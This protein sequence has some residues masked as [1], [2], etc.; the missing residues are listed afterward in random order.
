MFDWE[1]KD[2]HIHSV[3]TASREYQVHPKRLRK[4]LVALG[5]ILKESATLSDNQVTFDARQTDKLMKK[6]AT[7]ATATDVETYLG[8]GRV[9]TKILIENGLIIPFVGKDAPGSGLGELLFAREGLDA[10]LSQLF[11]DARPVISIPENA[12]SI[13][14][15]AKRANCGAAE[16]VRL[17]VDRKLKWVGRHTEVQGFASV[18]VDLQEIKDVVRGTARDGLTRQEITKILGVADKVTNALIEEGIL[19]QHTIRNPINRCPMQVIPNADVERFHDRYVSLF[20]LASA[21]RCHPR[22]LLR[23]LKEARIHPAFDP[24]K[25][26][27]RFYDRTAVT[28]LHIV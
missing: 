19:T 13:A 26:H 22:R 18:L 10:F 2:R 28:S 1:T 8:S 27:A 4:I 14:D 20:A 12:Y 24:I 7:S 17:I 16:I 6:I 23:G 21:R 5:V 3:Y 15:A 9:H 25:V 11:Q